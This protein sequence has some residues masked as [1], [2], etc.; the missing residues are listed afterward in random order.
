MLPCHYISISSGDSS[1]R[2]KRKRRCRIATCPTPGAAI[3]D[4]I[5][6][7]VAEILD[8]L[9][10]DGKSRDVD[11]VLYRLGEIVPDLR[12]VVPDAE[13]RSLESRAVEAWLED[14]KVAFYNAEDLL[15]EWNIEV[16]QLRE[17][18]SK[19]ERSKQVSPF[20]S[21]S[22]QLARGLKGIR[23]RM[24]DIA[25]RG[26]GL[27][28]GLGGY[29]KDVQVNKGSRKRLRSGTLVV[30]RDGAESATAAKSAID[31]DPQEHVEDVQV[32]RIEFGSV[33]VLSC[34]Y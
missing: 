27:G 20:L 3:A 24:D 31:V 9:A 25:S 5:V 14:V 1:K 15:E 26:R 34:H 2:K 32:E 10:R 19:D 6:S 28:L 18:S 23:M 7:K 22:D 16:K 29:P 13:R 30:G 4:A 11:G 33:A 21:P 8:G 17:S 12:K